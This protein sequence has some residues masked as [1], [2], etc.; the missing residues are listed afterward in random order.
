M[1]RNSG[2]DSVN[3]PVEVDELRGALE[4]AVVQTASEMASS[5]GAQGE[6]VAAEVAKMKQEEEEAGSP[7]SPPGSRDRG[8]SFFDGLFGGSEAEVG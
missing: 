7:G 3:D 6:A 2:F 4:L 5:G 1:A 8:V